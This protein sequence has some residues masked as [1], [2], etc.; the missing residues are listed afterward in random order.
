MT[1]ADDG[2]RD[3]YHEVRVGDGVNVVVGEKM[4]GDDGMA[5]L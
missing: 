5:K 2:A 1:Y 4:Y 3:G